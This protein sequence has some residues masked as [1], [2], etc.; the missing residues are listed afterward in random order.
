MS[1]S[2]LDWAFALPLRGAEKSV[3]VALANRANFSNISWPSQADISLCSG[4]SPKHVRTTIDRLSQRGLIVVTGRQGQLLHYILN[5][6]TSVVSSEVPARQHRNSVPKHRNS[7]PKTSVVSSHKPKEPIEPNSKPTTENKRGHRLPEDWQPDADCRAFAQ[8][9]GLDPEQVADHF[10][11]YW[12]DKT[13][14][15]ANKINWTGTWRNWCRTE[16]KR[17]PRSPVNT[18]EAIR[19]MVAEAEDSLARKPNP[20][21]MLRLIQ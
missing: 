18:A 12:H 6:G 2:A 21:P 9:H 13:G 16:A 11:D 14:A 8:S 15:N 5:V 10:R 4:L 1:N 19:R 20:T 17:K 3:L 7:V